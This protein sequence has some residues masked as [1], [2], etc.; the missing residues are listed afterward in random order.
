LQAE[1]KTIRRSGKMKNFTKNP[2][3]NLTQELK[4]SNMNSITGFLSELL[5]PG[6]YSAGGTLTF[7][8]ALMAVLIAYFGGILS[9]LTP[10]VYPMIPITVSVVGG[11]GPSRRAWHQV[12]V[13]GLVYVSGMAVVYSFLGVLAG[14]TGKVFGTL[15]NTP[16]WYLFLGSVMSLAALLMLDIVQFDPLIWWHGFKSK[17]GWENST[18]VTHPTTEE[19]TEL[20]L[21]GAFTLGASSGFIAAPCTTPVLTSILAYIAKTQ[22]I[23]LGLALML[24]FSLGLGTLL[25]VIAGFA[26]ALQILPRSGKWMKTVKIV[27]GLVLLIFADYLIYRAGSL[28]GV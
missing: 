11:V 16:G 6:A 9:S 27:S 21:L 12:W 13:R 28:G 10:C 24:S 20:S 3:Q 23:G 1:E 22:S 17:I 25:L 2:S 7:A 8:Q 4:M 14:L 5:N 18:K 15:T 19:K 26:G